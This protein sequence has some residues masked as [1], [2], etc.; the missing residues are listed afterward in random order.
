MPLDNQSLQRL[1]TIDEKSTIISTS[2][3]SLKALPP[4]PGGIP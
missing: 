4:P 1:E 2:Y 3:K